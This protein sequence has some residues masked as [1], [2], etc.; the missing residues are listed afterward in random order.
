MSEQKKQFDLSH[1]SGSRELDCPDCGGT[2]ILRRR[3]DDGIFYGC[4]RYPVCHGSHSA[5]QHDGTPMGIPAN[6]PTKRIRIKAHSSFD[7]IWESVRD[8]KKMRTKAYEW[9]AN[10]L[11]IP[12][13]ECH[14]GMFDKETCWKII[15]I[16]MEYAYGKKAAR[17]DIGCFLYVGDRNADKGKY[18]VLKIRTNG[19]P[20][21]AHEVVGDFKSKKSAIEKANDELDKHQVLKSAYINQYNVYNDRGDLLESIE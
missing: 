9:L 21:T 16:C 6:F 17:N 12:V 14:I 15:K 18:R 20:G 8:K 11:D 1:L 4:T 5:H 2:L 10:K 7:K 19:K 3:K 13:D